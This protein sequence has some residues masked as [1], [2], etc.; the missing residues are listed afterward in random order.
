M[1]HL[2]LTIWAAMFLGLLSLAAVI[3]AIGVGL[4]I[5]DVTRNL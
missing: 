4:L 1:I 3:F 5:I 2:A